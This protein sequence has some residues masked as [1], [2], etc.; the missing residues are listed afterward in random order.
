MSPSVMSHSNTRVSPSMCHVLACDDFIKCTYRVELQA[1]S[2]R[3]AKVMPV[4]L[5]HRILLLCVHRGGIGCTD[6]HT[7]TTTTTLMMWTA[8]ILCLLSRVCAVQCACVVLHHLSPRLSAVL[9]QRLLIPIVDLI[10]YDKHKQAL[11]T[12]WERIHGAQQMP[13]HGTGAA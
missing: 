1:P 3:E 5:E 8:H 6:M 11:I 9:P 4:P 7:T 10:L 12:R 2:H 13:R